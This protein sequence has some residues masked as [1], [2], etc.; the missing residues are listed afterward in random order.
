[1]QD[2][3]SIQRV[4][5]EDR[6][7]IDSFSLL[8][9]TMQGLNKNLLFNLKSCLFEFLRNTEKPEELLYLNQASR[10]ITPG[11]FWSLFLCVVMNI[12]VFSTCS[13]FLNAK[14]V[15]ASP[16]LDFRGSYPKLMCLHV[17]N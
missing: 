12:Y 13:K 8:F 17:S 15:N 2:L 1:M 9:S 5:L 11:W 10:I 7:L 14:Y 3:L 6:D 4:K 16:V